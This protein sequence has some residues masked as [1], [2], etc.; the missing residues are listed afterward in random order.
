MNANE[1]DQPAAHQRQSFVRVVK[2]LPH[3][4]GCAGLRSQVSEV[5][6]IFRAE[7]VFQEEEAVRLQVLGQANGHNG[8]HALMHVMQKLHVVAELFAQVFK[9]P[10]DRAA[11]GS[12]LPG[13][14]LIV[15]HGLRRSTAGGIG[16]NGP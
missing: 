8:R 11:I 14:R 10:G 7:R 4:N 15:R 12:R 3:G 16:G 1:V 6:D 9:E 2:Q 13:F 5:A